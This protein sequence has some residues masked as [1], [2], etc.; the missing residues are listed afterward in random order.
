MGDGFPVSIAADLLAVW[1]SSVLMS[2][3]PQRPA[4]RATVIGAEMEELFE[5]F[6]GNLPL[7]SAEEIVSE[8]WL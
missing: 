6:Q 1:W 5:L 4:T 2:N 8:Q 3:V 7:E